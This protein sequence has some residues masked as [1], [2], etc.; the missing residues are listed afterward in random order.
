M[1]SKMELVVDA[2]GD[3]RCIYGKELELREIGSTHWPGTFHLIG[4]PRR[5]GSIPW[6]STARAMTR[7]GAAPI[8]GSG[9]RIRSSSGRRGK[10]PRQRPVLS[11]AL[12]DVRGDCS[13][14]FVSSA[15]TRASTASRAD[16]GSFIPA[17]R[18]TARASNSIRSAEIASHFA[19]QPDT[20]LRFPE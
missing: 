8:R 17:T 10:A 20:T 9:G 18:T 3:V 14:A 4:Y 6:S 19:S 2:G 15:V 1:S 7:L 12:A 13:A 5:R 11:S 16:S